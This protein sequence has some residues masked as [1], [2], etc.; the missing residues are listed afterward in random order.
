MARQGPPDA[1]RRPQQQCCAGLALSAPDIR[2]SHHRRWVILAE[3]NYVRRGTTGHRG[4]R[5]G[6][7]TRLHSV[8]ARD[9]CTLQFCVL[10]TSQSCRYKIRMLTKYRFAKC[11]SRGVHFWNLCFLGICPYFP[12]RFQIC[13]PQDCQHFPT[14]FRFVGGFWGQQISELDWGPHINKEQYKG[15]LHIS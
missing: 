9:P 8:G 6:S 13:H 1:R 10:F 12:N 5:R 3:L 11:I 14:D 2:R 15:P 7:D 4:V